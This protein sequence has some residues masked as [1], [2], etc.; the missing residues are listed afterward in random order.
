MKNPRI[1][2]RTGADGRLQCRSDDVWHPVRVVRCFPW[3][4]AN[5]YISLRDSEG[6]ERTLVENP[7][8]LDAS[9]QT[10]LEHALT[11]SVNCLEIQKIRRI[12]QDIELRVWD[13]GTSAG[14]RKFQTELDT[15]PEPVSGGGWIVRDI[16]GDLYRIPRP[17]A[18]D[19]ASRRLLWAFLD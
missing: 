9:S 5:G 6:R 7:G 10:A 8:D 16:T 18:L 17:E 1:E 2:L 3:I 12:G 11:T 4:S 19:V 14:D 13:V 15:W